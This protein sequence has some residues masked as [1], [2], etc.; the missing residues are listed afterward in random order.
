MPSTMNK[1]W[2]LF[3][4]AASIAAAIASAQT[5]DTSNLDVNRGP[6]LFSFEK[7]LV[8]GATYLDSMTLQTFQVQSSGGL[9]AQTKTETI[10]TSELKVMDLSE[11]G[12]LVNA[13]LTGFQINID[14]SM[15]SGN[16][17]MSTM[18]LHCDISQEISTVPYS[19]I[20]YYAMKGG[21]VSFVIDDQGTVADVNNFTELVSTISPPQ[22]VEA[23][24]R[25]M[26]LLP[27]E[28]FSPGEKYTDN[29]PL[30]QDFGQFDGTVTL[31]GYTT[32]QGYDVAVFSMQGNLIMSVDDILGKMDP[33]AAGAGMTATVQQAS[34][35]SYLFWDNTAKIARKT[36]TTLTASIELY[37]PVQNV[38]VALPIN[39][40]ITT[41][42]ALKQ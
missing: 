16:S 21:H 29:I 25:L 14:S 27:P 22:T 34:M 30:D 39:E 36:Q 15:G 6:A 13:S 20:P 35:A 23:A 7:A 3:L 32:Y 24:S 1:F 9:A 4:Y 31:E 28:S 18:N 40:I 12:Q 17:S 19:C 42:S 37:N 8:G 26:K 5:I 11:G 2:E 41:T 33:N 38:R 10:M